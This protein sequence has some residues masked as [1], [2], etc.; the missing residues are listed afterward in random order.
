MAIREYFHDDKKYF[1]V[2]LNLRGRD[3]KRVRKQTRIRFDP[4]GNRIESLS[5]AR[6]EEKRLLRNLTETVNKLEGK[7]Y[8]WREI[9]DRWEDE[10]LTPPTN[11]VART[12]AIDHAQLMRNWTT[13]WLDRPAS[14]IGR[15]EV[16]QLFRETA[17]KGKSVKFQKSIKHTINVIYKWAIEERL[18]REVHSSP[19]TGVEI[20][21]RSE[22]K[23]PEILTMEQLRILLR[24]AHQTQHPWFP[25]WSVAYF[26]GGRSGEL[27]GF[28]KEDCSIVAKE[29]GL[30]QDK[31]P[32]EKRNYGTISILRSWSKRD[33]KYMPTKGRYWRNVPVSGE[34]Y[35]FLQ[36]L[37]AQDF[38]GDEHGRFLLPRFSDWTQGL[39]AH[40]LR[41]FCEE[42]GLPSIKFHTLRACFA[43]H[44]LA[45]GV[46]SI[47]VM[48]AGGW[49]N[50]KTMEI[51]ARLAGVD[52][53]GITEV[54]D[55]MPSTVPAAN[56]VNLFQ[57][58]PKGS[59]K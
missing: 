22:E 15:G 41:A 10:K 21:G 26:T 1:E 17:A 3:V 35:W 8:L 53:A 57:F 13:E 52:I 56:V 39:Q 48:K 51:Y 24:E 20:N 44:L 16:R 14:E 49:K 46:P 18:I 28:R 50:L 47:K 38:G 45:L 54:L 6:T 31:L 42:I 30:D 7:G 33:N 12:T 11:D 37:I 27:Q 32:P 9:V 43:T 40:I 23:K 36:E 34:L 55:A 58:R 5:S 2:A 25:I 59:E 29:V 4:K 19:T